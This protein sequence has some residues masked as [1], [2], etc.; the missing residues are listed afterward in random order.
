MFRVL[1]R[2]AVAA[3]FVGLAALPVTAS[4]SG[5]NGMQITVGKP[6]TVQAHVLVTVPV[7]VTC[8]TTI[9]VDPNVAQ[10]GSI[11]AGVK[12]AGKNT[13]AHGSGGLTL[14]TCSPTPSTY[15][16]QVTADNA[17]F[18]RGAAIVSTAGNICDGS[19]FPQVCYFS[20]TTWVVV[21][22]V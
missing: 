11:S 22:L 16:I 18:H 17:P 10:P 6:I 3:A 4:A 5:G 19:V 15:L 12:Q 1:G 13:V 2:F 9:T 8:P 21:T 14:L 20:D 7:S